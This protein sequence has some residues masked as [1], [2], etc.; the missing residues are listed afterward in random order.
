ML[1]CE[2]DW[3][4]EVLVWERFADLRLFRYVTI[5]R[6][7]PAYHTLFRCNLKMIRHDYPHIQKWL[8]HLYYNEA[9][10][11]ETTYFDAVSLLINIICETFS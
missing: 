5:V 6:F 2:F 11:R 3:S 7:D 8:M 1:G 10:F 9:A 4:L